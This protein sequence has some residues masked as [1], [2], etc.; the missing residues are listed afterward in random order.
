MSAHCSAAKTH[1]PPTHDRQ[2]RSKTGTDV[3]DT[4]DE[5]V[6]AEAAKASLDV[7]VAQ[8]QVSAMTYNTVAASC[9]FCS[10]PDC[11]E[12]ARL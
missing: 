11:W 9:R 6:A 4:G 7:D 3:D 10:Q 5:A 8:L 1:Q 2:K 12:Q